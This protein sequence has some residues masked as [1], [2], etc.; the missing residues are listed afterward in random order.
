MGLRMPRFGALLAIS[1]VV[2]IF[3]QAVKWL[4]AARLAE[5]DRVAV[6]PFFRSGALAQHGRR[7]RNPI[8]R[9]WVAEQPIFFCS[10]WACLRFWGFSCAK[11]RAATTRYGL[12][13]CR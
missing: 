12:R 3:D 1:A 5:L 10:G 6:L 11:R 13:A 4:V 2:A 9:P 7:L 8:Q